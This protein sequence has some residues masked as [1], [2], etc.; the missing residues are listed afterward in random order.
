MQREQYAQA[1]EQLEAGTYGYPISRM[2]L[3]P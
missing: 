1:V 2:T 3:L